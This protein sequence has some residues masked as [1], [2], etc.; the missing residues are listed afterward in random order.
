MTPTEEKNLA[1]VLDWVERSHR[2]SPHRTCSQLRGRGFH[3][4][5][6]QCSY[7][8]SCFCERPSRASGLRSSRFPIELQILPWS[9]ERREISSGWSLS[10]KTNDLKDTSPSVY[11]YSFDLFRIQNGKIQEHSDSARQDPGSA[12]FIPPATAPP[13]STWNT[14]KP[15]TAE[16]QNLAIATRFEKNVVEYGHIPRTSKSFF[17]HPSSRAQSRRGAR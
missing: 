15:S 4:A 10:T 6:P 8:S 3:P 12:A 14:A 16:Q 11:I 2:S 5:Q 7:W 1:F 13:P 17:R 9:R